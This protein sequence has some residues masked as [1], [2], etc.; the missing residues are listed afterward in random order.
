M[1]RLCTVCSH[2]R[3][4]GINKDLTLGLGL[5]QTSQKY[6]QW[7]KVSVYAL[8]RHMAGHIS[9]KA[10]AAII[11]GNQSR[12]D[13]IDLGELRDTTEKRNLADLLYHRNVLEAEIVRAREMVD[14]T[15]ISA[16]EGRLHQNIEQT[17]RLIGELP[18]QRLTLNLVTN[19]DDWPAL[20]QDLLTVARLVPQAR[21]PLLELVHKRAH[22]SG[23]PTTILN[24]IAVEVPGEL[25]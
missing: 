8:H 10:K 11:A 25:G 23:V 16:L 17:S 9:D 5:R 19:A 22:I 6:R 13:A 24:G 18:T 4:S 20:Q 1:G 15:A 2:P 21:K 7:G 12:Q 3:L 14:F